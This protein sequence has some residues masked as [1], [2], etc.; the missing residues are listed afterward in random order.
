[1]LML[2]CKEHAFMIKD[3]TELLPSADLSHLPQSSHTNTADRV[4]RMKATELKW[5]AA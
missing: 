1:M 2:L 4:H 5:P 3:P